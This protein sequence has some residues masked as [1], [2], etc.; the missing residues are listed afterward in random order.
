MDTQSRP[1]KKNSSSSVVEESQKG[2]NSTDSQPQRTFKLHEITLI[3]K[4][5]HL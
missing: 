3:S 2:Y 4:E 1:P 5:R